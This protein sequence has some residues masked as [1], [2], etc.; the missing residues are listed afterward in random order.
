MGRPKG[1]KNKPKTEFTPPP[2]PSS[3]SSS[4]SSQSLPLTSEDEENLAEYHA[5]EKW[6][7]LN[8]FCAHCKTEVFP[9]SKC[10]CPKTPI[11]LKNTKPY[12]TVNAANM[13]KVRFFNS[14][15]QEW[16]KPLCF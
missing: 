2:S 3:A 5:K 9:G 15:R 1:S 8:I 7:T 10:K 13:D 16:F 4:A 14:V 12:L 6:G 11:E